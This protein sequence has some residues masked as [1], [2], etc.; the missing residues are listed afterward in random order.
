MVEVS[1]IDFKFIFFLPCSGQSV[2]LAS[3]LPENKQAK[4][5]KNDSATTDANIF[6][7]QT[8]SLFASPRF[9]FRD[10]FLFFYRPAAFHFDKWRSAPL[11]PCRVGVS[12]KC[13]PIKP[14]WLHGLFSLGFRLSADPNVFGFELEPLRSLQFN[15]CLCIMIVSFA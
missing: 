5:T 12:A 2:D 8:F 13:Q 7:L 14:T 6:G 10:G 3:S 9:V 15:Y 4:I 11:R 1:K